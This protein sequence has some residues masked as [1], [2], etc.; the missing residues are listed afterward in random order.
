LAWSGVLTED[1]VAPLLGVAGI[2]LPQAWRIWV[3]RFFILCLGAFLLLFGLW[4]EV[5]GAVWDYLAVTGTMYVAGAMTLV[6]MGLYWRR[7]NKTGAYVGL[8]CGAAPGVIYLAL[9]ITT[10]I[11]EPAVKNA[12]HVPQHA[13]AKLSAAMTEPVTGV[14]SFPLALVGMI[15]GSLWSGRRGSPVPALRPEP[16]PV[17][18][19]AAAREEPNG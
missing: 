8:I 14:I 7:A 10:L 9:R 16:T 1:L 5:E 2:D 6:A 11:I 12:G 17:L 19:A 15:V 3:T 4:F 18:E 13:I